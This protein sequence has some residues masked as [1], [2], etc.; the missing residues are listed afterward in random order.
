[1]MKKV[2]ICNIECLDDIS[3]YNKAYSFLSKSR[4]LKLS[5]YRNDLEKKLCIGGEILLKYALREETNL[6]FRKEILYSFNNFNKPYLK[7]NDTYFNISH[8]GKYCICAL[9]N[10]EIGVDIQ[11]MEDIKTNV[12]KRFFHPNEYQYLELFK[13][14]KKPFYRLWT[15]KEAFIKCIGDGLNIPLN[16]FEIKLSNK[17]DVVQKIDKNKYY[18]REFDYDNC[19]IAICQMEDND[20]EL[21]LIDLNSLLNN[22]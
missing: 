3:L 19:H 9:D 2:Y 1:M 7:N 17:V 13:N 16:S 5:K 18:F 21:C 12:A 14:K 15:L 11:A 4:K 22:L 8:S 6:D 20:F 10:N